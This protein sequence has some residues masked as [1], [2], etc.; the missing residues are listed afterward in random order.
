[1]SAYTIINAVRSEIVKYSNVENL[2]NFHRAHPEYRSLG[3]GSFTR[4]RN[5]SFGDILDFLVYPRSK[6]TDIELLEF[7]RLIGRPNVNK[8]DF[9]RRR[10]LIPAAY[11]KSMNRD[12]VSG[13]YASQDA[14]RWHGHLLLAADGTTYSLPD[15]PE[16]K[17]KYLQGRR[18]GRGEQPLARGVVVKDVLNDLVVTSDMECYGKDEIGLLLGELDQLPEAVSGMAPV[19]VLDRKFCAYT[20]LSA[21]VRKGIGFIIRVKQR[22]RPADDS[23]K[24]SGKTSA[25]IV[26]T[27]APTTVK[28]LRRLF[29]KEAACTFPVRLVRLNADVVVMTSVSD[30]SLKADSTDPYHL[31]WDAETTIGFVKNNLQVEIFSSYLDNSMRQDFHARTIQYNLLS[32]ICR[33]AAALRHDGGDRRIDRNVALGILKLEFGVFIQPDSPSFNEYLQIVL[34]EI[35]RFTTPLRPGRHNPR[36]FRKIKH[37]GKYITLH[38]YREAI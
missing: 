27:P 10:R 22:F 1:M 34:K 36:V 5:L 35:A 31:R 38:N 28:K 16:I 7:S 23:F 11:L 29:G 8:S 19:V 21:L 12:I 32:V 25:D 13:I 20:L 30:V 3:D 18:T 17:Q 4:D 24:A 37:S 2:K 9:S 6:S 26:L 14:A 33:Q 15:T